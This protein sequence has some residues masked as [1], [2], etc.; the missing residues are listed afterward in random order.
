MKIQQ[1]TILG[2][3]LLLLGL[4]TPT[5]ATA[6]D[7]ETRRH[8]DG[9]RLT[10]IDSGEN[11]KHKYP[12]EL[13]LISQS[14]QERTDPANPNQDFLQPIEP[15]TPP[16]EAEPLFPQPEETT[17]PELPDSASFPIERINIE[18]STIFTSAD[19]APL[20]EPLTGQNVTL[21]Q[22]R[23][24]ADAI[25]QLYLDQGY[26]NSR[27]LLS[28]QTITDGVATIEVIE[29]TITDIEISG[30][31]RFLTSYFT[32]RLNRGIHT[33]LNVNQ[34]EDQLRLLQINPLIEDLEVDLEPAEVTGE[35]ILR[36]EVEEARPWFGSVFIDNYSAASVG[37]ER[38]GISGGYRNLIGVGDVFTAT[39]TRSFTGGSTIFDFNY[40]VPFNSLDGTV[41]LRATIDRNEVTQSPFDELGIEGESETYEI[42]VRQPIKR[43]FGEEFALSVGLNHRDGQTFLFD[44]VGT[45]FGSGAEA[46]GTTRTTVLSFGQ[47]YLR[48]DNQGAWVLRSQF[49]FG[50]DILDA[51][52][53]PDPIPDGRFF[54]WNGQV[55]RIHQLTP[56]QLLIVQGNIQLSPDNLLGSQRFT[57]GGGQTLR[58][59][60]QGARSGD[61]G[62]RLSVED[63][64]T[65]IQGQPG[66]SL[67]QVAPFFDMGTVWN[68][69]SNP[70]QIADE[71]FLAGLGTG[72][73]Y[74]PIENLTLRMDF[75]I[76]L[77]NLSDRSSNI[78]D[79]GIYFSVNYNL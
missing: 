17:P 15:I 35:S 77:V 7:A 18:G 2:N 74:S 8:G 42:S 61:N 48:R 34:L 24:V 69:P 49:N 60:R 5:I 3:T 70:D 14:P 52:T 43:S 19:F 67:L 76:P 36:L 68:N 22:L 72:I 47:D 29:G 39:G 46:D 58:G 25:T 57:I 38:F 1:V 79:D 73:I 13:D 6:G 11:L 45:A 50:L 33:P 51:T 28:E 62:W 53:N 78:Q 21:N 37:S 63:R 71:H 16:P 55:Q 23:G 65:L 30:Q 59:Y 56:K 40:L 32:S 10:I 75:T 26:I 20:I 9:S 12:T 4:V 54:N 31:Q 27:A 64:I 44:N 41:Q 66:V